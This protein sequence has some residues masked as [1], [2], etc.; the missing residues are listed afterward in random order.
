MPSARPWDGKAVIYGVTGML[1]LTSAL[2]LDLPGVV[3]HSERTQTPCGD[4]NQEE[5]TPSAK[6]RAV[7]HENTF[8][9]CT[10][11]AATSAIAGWLSLPSGSIAVTL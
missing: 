1:L 10:A 4:D 11:E 5:I 3:W 9:R 2:V 8:Y 6:R 7:P